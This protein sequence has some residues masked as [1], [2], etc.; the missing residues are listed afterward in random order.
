VPSPTHGSIKFYREYYTATSVFA[1]LRG[2][3]KRYL[4]KNV[5]GYQALEAVTKTLKSEHKQQ[6]HVLALMMNLHFY[7]RKNANIISVGDY[8]GPARY[9]DLYNEL[10]RSEDCPSY[11][12]RLNISAVIAQPEPRPPSAWWPRYYAKLRARLKQCDYIE[13]RCGANT[14]VFLKSDI[15]P[16]ASL[17]P[18]L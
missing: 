1:S 16:Y 11:F 5:P 4:E 14:A 10:Y 15:T 8:F 6:T 13:Y 9:R 7:F 2:D 3:R 18:V 17:Q 12:S